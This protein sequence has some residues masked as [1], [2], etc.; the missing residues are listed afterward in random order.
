[1]R[2]RP[3]LGQVWLRSRPGL[4]Q[5]WLRSGS[6]LAQVWLRYGPELAQDW[7]RT[8][9]GLD[10]DWIRSGQI[11]VR[12]RVPLTAGIPVPCLRGENYGSP[13]GMS[14]A[15]SNGRAEPTLWSRR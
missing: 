9:S 15:G 4:G 12:P 1:M 6:G 5:V 8:G 14:T 3:G 2:S 13:H 10:Q 7:I 11:R